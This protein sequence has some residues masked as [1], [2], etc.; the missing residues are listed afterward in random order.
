MELERSSTITIRVTRRVATVLARI[1]D[2]AGPRIRRNVSGRLTV[3][4]TEI[5]C[6]PRLLVYLIV[7]ATGPVAGEGGGKV[8]IQKLVRDLFTVRVGAE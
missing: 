7:R 3:A 4:D 8:G 5:V 6:V 2:S 1:V